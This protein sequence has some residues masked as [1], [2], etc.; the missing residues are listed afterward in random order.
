MS[1]TGLDCPVTCRVVAV[2][3]VDVTVNL[4]RKDTGVPQYVPFV[5][6]MQCLVFLWTCTHAAPAVP[7]KNV[8][9]PWFSES[10][11]CLRFSSEYV[12]RK[13]CLHGTMDYNF[14]GSQIVDCKL[15]IVGQR[16]KYT[17]LLIGFVHLHRVICL[18]HVYTYNIL[19]WGKRGCESIYSCPFGNA[20]VF[21]IT[22]YFL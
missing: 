2:F 19:N 17:L 8:W 9:Q 20:Y 7:I 1:L 14:I 6:S 4:L 10:A 18:I 22:Q 13:W 15:F 16:W 11:V 21:P 12:C 3:G 5:L